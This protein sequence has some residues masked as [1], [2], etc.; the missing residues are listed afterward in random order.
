MGAST[1]FYVQKYPQL[2]FTNKNNPSYYVTL[3]DGIKSPSIKIPNQTCRYTNN[4]IIVNVNYQLKAGLTEV[5]NQ[6]A[7]ANLYVNIYNAGNDFTPGA[8][9]LD[10]AKR[11]WKF[12]GNPEVELYAT[13]TGA[14]NAFAKNIVK[15]SET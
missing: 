14:G 6:R 4:T 7:D 5:S 10:P 12:Y 13:I 2:D 11:G 8:A 1:D 9:G 3:F 15:P